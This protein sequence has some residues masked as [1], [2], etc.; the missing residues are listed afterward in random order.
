MR[1]VFAAP[2]LLIASVAAADDS[3]DPEKAADPFDS[4]LP[5]VSAVVSQALVN[6]VTKCILGEGDTMTAEDQQRLAA[7][8]PIFDAAIQNAGTCANSPSEQACA[9]AIRRLTCDELAGQL[10]PSI[11]GLATATP[12][13]WA[14]AYAQ[15]LTGKVLQCAAAEND[16]GTPP[17]DTSAL[18]TYTAQIARA[19]GAMTSQ[20]TC[21]VNQGK[22]PACLS[23]INA[24][25]CTALGAILDDDDLTAVASVVDGC[26][27]LILCDA[28]AILADA[29]G[30]GA[31]SEASPDER[32]TRSDAGTP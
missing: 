16:G 4:A 27:E 22:L 2:I 28:S 20:G 21:S 6:A 32:A 8:A 26:Q 23:S 13:A 30:A 25:S 5:T 19:F 31:A 15:G 10:A 9:A 17:V 29:D 7:A 14:T 3:Y 24:C 18:A 1:T 11:P 12:P